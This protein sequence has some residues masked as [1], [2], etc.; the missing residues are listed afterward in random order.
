VKNAQIDAASANARV[1]EIRG[2]GLPQVSAQAQIIHN[3]EIQKVVLEN[4]GPDF[5]SPDLPVAPCCPFPFQL[6][7]LGGVTLNRQPAPVRR[8][9]FL[10]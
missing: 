8:S 5:G 4:G 6:K 9:Y 1:G 7:N 10:G 2:I 3:I